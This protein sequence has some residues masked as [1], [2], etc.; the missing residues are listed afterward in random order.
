M[1]AFQPNVLA[2]NALKSPV[3]FGRDHRH[4]RR[5][6]RCR[7]AAD[8]NIHK[9]PSA[10]YLIFGAGPHKQQRAQGQNNRHRH[11]GRFSDKE[12]SK[13]RTDGPHTQ[14]LAR[15]PGMGNNRE[16]TTGLRAAAGSGARPPPPSPQ[17]RTA[18]RCTGDSLHSARLRRR[19]DIASHG[20][21]QHHGP[22]AEY[23]F[24]PSR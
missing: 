3:P 5:G 19:P 15:W 2:M 16:S 11:G 9:T 20:A 10:R 4:R 14:T 23:N 1:A 7:G 24:R 17:T 18:V 13:G 22:E 6:K 21:H 8:G 12:P